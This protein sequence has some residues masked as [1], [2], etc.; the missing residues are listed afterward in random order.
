[1]G[2]RPNI[3]C[4]YS[5]EY[6]AEYYS[7]KNLSIRLCTEHSVFFRMFWYSTEYTGIRP[8]IM[9]SAETY[10]MSVGQSLIP[11]KAVYE[12]MTQSAIPRLAVPSLW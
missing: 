11:R 3:R 2:I 8:N 10:I 9:Y 1:M 4:Y 7:P 5:A 12:L 6:S